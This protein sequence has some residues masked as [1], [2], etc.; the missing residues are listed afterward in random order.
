MNRTA[1]SLLLGALFTVPAVGQSNGS[2][3]SD[4]APNVFLFRDV[5]AH[6]VNDLV[7]ILVV[8]NS[9]ATNSA[10]TTTQKKGDATVN[11]PA[12]LGIKTPQLLCPSTPRSTS[13]VRARPPGPVN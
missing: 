9:T 3:Y 7:T 13:P 6:N 4:T 1:G 12:F 2:L 11:T 8:E 5:R 10:N